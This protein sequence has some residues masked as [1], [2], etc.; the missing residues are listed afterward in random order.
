[1]SQSLRFPAAVDNRRPFGCHRY[2]VRSPK[3]GRR[4]T[5]FGEAALN[6][7]ISIE[8]N[9]QIAAFC[10]RPAVSRSQKPARVVDFWVQLPNAEELWLLRRGREPQ[11]D[12][13]SSIAPS[14]RS[15][16]QDH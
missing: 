4:V 10:E 15:W 11:E 7:W 2:V 6:A 8:A 16:A 14:F 13:G 1:L 5:L 3:I 12:P 9:P